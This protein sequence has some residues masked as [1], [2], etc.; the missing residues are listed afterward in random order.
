[1]GMWPVSGNSQQLASPRRKNGR[2]FIASRPSMSPNARTP[3]L[4]EYS[5]SHSPRAVSVY[6]APTP[7]SQ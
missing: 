1:M 3:N 5:S 6:S 4:T 2:P 7:S